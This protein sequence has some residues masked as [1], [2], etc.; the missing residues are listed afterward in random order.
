MEK[1]PLKINNEV[2]TL[3]LNVT[4][5][6]SILIRENKRKEKL[7]KEKKSVEKKKKSFEKLKNKEKIL[8]NPKKIPVVGQVGSNI[9]KTGQNIIDKIL[10]FGGL[11]L[12]GI[13]VNNLPKIIETVRGIID[14][15]V[16]FLTPIQSGFNL[17]KGLFIGE[18]DKTKY[19]ADKKRFDDSLSQL[20]E[21]G[22]L[23]D[24]I[25]ENAGP[26]E[27][28]IK[29]LKPAIELFRNVA[30][31]K[32]K[33]LAVKNGQEGV[34]NNTTGEFT[35]RQF[36][37]AERDKYTGAGGRGAGGSSGGGGG[38]GGGYNGGGPVDAPDLKTA[39]RQLES[40]NDYRSMY[41]RDRADFSRGKEDITKMTIDEVD[42]LQT[43]YLNHQASKGYGES[44]R[45][46]AMGAYQM[47]E[48]KKVAKNMELDTSKVLF[49]KE[50]QDLMSNSWLND[51]GYQEWKAG[52][53]TDAVFNDRLAGAFASIKKT[54][55]VGAYDNDGMN[56][57][58]GN[59]MPLLKR[60]KKETSTPSPPED[61][62]GGPLTL[63]PSEIPGENATPEEMDEYE[64]K[65]AEIAKRQAAVLK[66]KEA[67]PPLSEKQ[68]RNLFEN[69]I[70]NSNK[71]SKKDKEISTINQ[72]IDDEEEGTEVLVTF[73]RIYNTKTIPFPTYIPV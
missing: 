38:G 25:A 11:I 61:P 17:L 21:D 24:Q 41:A 54:S 36:T 57:A 56:N 20:S 51:A 63:D 33:V 60:L 67:S 70:D 29:F 2:K 68:E 48:V 7:K 9:K 30:G 62:S 47:I 3:K 46:A 14:S 15:I 44:Q 58:Y 69:W 49:N 64:R 16:N 66:E 43:D 31:G 18:I 34:K 27:G 12:S 40:G 19:D 10:N 53:I 22:G 13:L 52:K 5:I 39:I 55:G 8:E 6:R 59:I 28:L 42:Q 73:Q 26:L 1:T 37:Q 23:I 45:S 4:N 35:P 72:P 71:R 32:D 50:T 65:L